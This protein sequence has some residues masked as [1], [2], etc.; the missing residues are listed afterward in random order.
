MTKDNN[1]IICHCAEIR[2]NEILNAINN[3]AHTVEDISEITDAGI[4]CGYCIEG[5]EE[6]LETELKK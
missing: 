6:I 2:Y 1:E 4:A 3:G 5:I